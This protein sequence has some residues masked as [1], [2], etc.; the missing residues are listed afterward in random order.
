MEELGILKLTIAGKERFLHFGMRCAQLLQK[1]LSNH[2]IDAF[3]QVASFMW[4]GLMARR[5]DNDLPKDFSP[6]DCIDWIDTISM[7]EN[8]NIIHLA[9]ES[10]GFIQR[11]TAAIGA[12]EAKPEPVAEKPISKE[13]AIAQGYQIDQPKTKATVILPSVNGATGIREVG[14]GITS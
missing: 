2:E 14:I 12:P 9:K 4:A 8:E 3:Q 13:Q 1:Q 7:E 5:L 10:L 11:L 6:D